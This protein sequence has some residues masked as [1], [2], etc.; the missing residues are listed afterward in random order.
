MAL[1]DQ[2]MGKPMEAVAP[3]T[4]APETYQKAVQTSYDIA[5]NQERLRIADEQLKLQQDQNKMEYLAK[6][7]NAFNALAKAKGPARRTIGDVTIKYF[8]AAGIEPDPETTKWIFSDEATTQTA[9]EVI[10]NAQKQGKTS[11]EMMA[12]IQEG[13]SQDPE[14]AKPY[15]DAIVSGQKATQEMTKAINVEAI[16]AKIAE[17]KSDQE[18]LSKVKTLPITLQRKLQGEPLKYQAD[19]AE[20]YQQGFGTYYDEL[21]LNIKDLKKTDPIKAAKAINMAN[22]AALKYADDP[23]IATQMLNDA[24]GLITEIQAKQE[25][26]SKSLKPLS[27]KAIEALSTY[28]DIPKTMEDV[29]TVIEQNKSYFGPIRGRALRIGEAIGIQTEVGGT[30]EGILKNVKQTIGKLKEGGVLRLEDEKK[31][32]SILPSIKDT[33]EVAKNKA[34][35]VLRDMNT[36]VKTFI[37]TSKKAGRDVSLFESD[38]SKLTV[39]PLP[40]VVTGKKTPWYLSNFKKRYPNLTSEQYDKYIKKAEADGYEVIK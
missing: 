27:D 19:V 40:S 30:L 33:P 35:L 28:Q 5:Q 17:K 14:M 31:Y 1:V 22:S 16:R 4:G 8:R 32:E 38:I 18:R 25:P 26:K 29:K 34:D 20:T 15:F 36:K 23:E 39:P 9:Y 24:Q 6:G 21:I 7:I 10:K 12:L 13:F 2:L 3:L 11:L 37:E